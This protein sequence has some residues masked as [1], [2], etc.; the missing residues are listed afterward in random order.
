MRQEEAPP[1][2][3]SQDAGPDQ[4][5]EQPTIMTAHRVKARTFRGRV[6]HAH[7]PSLTRPDRTGRPCPGVAR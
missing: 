5:A 2:H 3:P 6:G 7:G 1:P 4:K